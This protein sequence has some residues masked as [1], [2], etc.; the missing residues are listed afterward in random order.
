MTL[1]DGN[2]PQCQLSLKHVRR[3]L[4]A[5][6]ACLCQLLCVIC[7]TT[8]REAAVAAHSSFSNAFSSA[9]DVSTKRFYLFIHLYSHQEMQISRQKERART[10]YKPKHN[11]MQRRI[12]SANDT[13][14]RNLEIKL[15]CLRSNMTPMASSATKAQ[16]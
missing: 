11:Y 13:L 16:C 7:Y 9:D 15:S 14:Q 4:A 12:A 8:S 6:S 1:V 2:I 3:V 5:M 10:N